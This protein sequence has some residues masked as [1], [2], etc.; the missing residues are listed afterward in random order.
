MFNQLKTICII[1]ILSIHTLSSTGLVL[2]NSNL[3]KRFSHVLNFFCN[4]PIAENR[5][6][7]E[8]FKLESPRESSQ[9]GFQILK[10]NL[11]IGQ[12]KDCS[13]D[14]P[15]QLCPSKTVLRFLPNHFPSYM[16][17][18]ECTCDKCLQ[19][20]TQRCKAAFEF[21]K[22]L[23]LDKKRC[24]WQRSLRKKVIGCQC[25]D[26]KNIEIFQTC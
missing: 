21:E 20:G 14:E 18:Q 7:L 10:R 25:I 16:V 4:T 13:I 12:E 2:T 15:V 24:D 19:S 6:K 26:K 23:V 11:T 3:I 5:L 22:V 8:Q 9:L 1:F 17:E